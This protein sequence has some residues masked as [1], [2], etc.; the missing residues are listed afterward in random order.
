M[1]IWVEVQKI[2]ERP[3][4]LFVQGYC[5]ENKSALHTSTKESRIRL[6]CNELGI[7]A[8]KPY[9]QQICIASRLT[10]RSPWSPFVEWIGTQRCVYFVFRIRRVW[11]WRVARWERIGI[12]LWPRHPFLSGQ[13]NFFVMSW[14]SSR[15]AWIFA[16]H[17]G[18]IVVH[19][20]WNKVKA[21]CNFCL[22]LRKDPCCKESP[23]ISYRKANSLWS[24]SSNTVQVAWLLMNGVI[25][26]INSTFNI[27]KR[28]PKWIDHVIDPVL[29]KC[30]VATSLKFLGKG[31]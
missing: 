23:D 31:Y 4:C 6:C 19:S 14:K 20:P 5:P 21:L 30:F 17:S 9:T 12:L 1:I 3:V 16:W 24:H 8:S 13:L 7:S 15:L 11:I 29:N 10:G 27:P 26:I 28:G 22:G 2:H 25:N 18:K